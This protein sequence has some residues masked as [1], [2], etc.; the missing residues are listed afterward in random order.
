LRA[1]L[2]AS[3]YC[4][5]EVLAFWRVREGQATIS[6]GRFNFYRNEAAIIPDTLDQ[7]Q[8]DLE[9]ADLT[10]PQRSFV[11]SFASRNRRLVQSKRTFL[12]K[13]ALLYPDKLVHAITKL[14]GP[15]FAPL[16]FSR[17]KVRALLSG[18]QPCIP[19]QMPAPPA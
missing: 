10:E 4:L 9:K 6:Y 2:S 1:S 18:K 17:I 16:W 19:L 8:F 11:T 13:L 12:L 3:T 15:N 5:D 14:L 7:M